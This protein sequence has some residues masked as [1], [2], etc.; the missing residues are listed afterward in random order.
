MSHR[1]SKP[2][3]HAAALLALLLAGCAQ[4]YQLTPDGDGVRW[5]RGQALQQSETPGSAVTLAFLGEDRGRL[6]FNVLVENRGSTDLL[7]APEAFYY[8]V[9][10]TTRRDPGT[11]RRAGFPDED[12]DRVM[13]LDPERELATLRGLGADEIA[14]IADAATR[15]AVDR[16]DAEDRAQGRAL[17]RELRWWRDAALR[18]T[19]LAPGQRMGGVVALPAR[20]RASRLRLVLPLGDEEP[21]F[22]F[23]QTLD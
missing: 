14:L 17:N 7:V 22:D 4:T 1:G 19:T 15:D 9:L 6:L 11:T 5:Y 10:E 23:S 18:K 21:S 2:V 8:D 20:E 13:A 16:P 3:L 12:M